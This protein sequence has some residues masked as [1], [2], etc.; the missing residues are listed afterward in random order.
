MM[1]EEMEG[2]Y[3]KYGFYGEFIY[4]EAYPN[5]DEDYLDEQWWYVN[6]SDN[7]MVSTHGR[8]WSIKSQKMLKPKRLDKHGH[9]GCCL[10]NGTKGTEKYRYIH[11]LMAE[12]FLPK[13]DGCDV[14]RHLNDDPTYNFIDNLAWGTQKDNMHDCMRNDGFYYFTDEDRRKAHLKQMTPVV[15]TNCK[16]GEELYF[17]SLSKAASD[18]GIHQANIWKVVN[19]ERRTAGGYMFRRS[20]RLE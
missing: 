11:R 7:Y 1:R 3:G 19:G 15:A 5:A 20:E 8:V 17:E 2:V 6:D 18:L 12:A 4:P 9:I 16:T 13:P 14:V 10:C